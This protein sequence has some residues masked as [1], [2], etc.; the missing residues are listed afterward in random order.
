[1]SAAE[2]DAKLHAARQARRDLRAAQL[3]CWAA[4]DADDDD[5]AQRLHYVVLGHADRLRELGARR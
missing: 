4:Q 2:L 5:E 1:M 3:A